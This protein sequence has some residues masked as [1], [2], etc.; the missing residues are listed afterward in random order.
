MSSERDEILKHLQTQTGLMAQILQ[1][2]K[3]IEAQ[4]G[5]S[6][7]YQWTPEGLPICPRHGEAMAKREKQGDIWYSH[8]VIDPDTGEVH[9]CKGY[10]SPS[11]PGWSIDAGDDD[12]GQSPPASHIEPLDVQRT[13]APTKS[14]PPGPPP[15]NVARVAN[16][17]KPVEGDPRLAF[18]ELGGKAMGEGKIAVQKFNSI[19]T[20]AGNQGWAAALNELQMVLG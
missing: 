14:Q 5:A 10:A 3:R 6:S 2:L 17:A 15:P 8:K 4:Q 12:S 16:I 7:A 19:V 1:T 11:S 13:A 18:Y 9:F 20:K